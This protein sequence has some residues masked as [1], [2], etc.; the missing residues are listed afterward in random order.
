MSAASETKFPHGQTTTSRVD[1]AQ[2][3]STGPCETGELVTATVERNRL[4]SELLRAIVK[5]EA[6]RRQGSESEFMDSVPTEG[7]AISRVEAA[8]A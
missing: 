6:R 2:P 3:A 7:T 5:N 1:A 4:R 8:Q